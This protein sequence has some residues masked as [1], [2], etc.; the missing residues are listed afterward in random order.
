MVYVSILRTAE[1]V[2]LRPPLRYVLHKPE[3]S[4]RVQSCATGAII[5]LGPGLG[6]PEFAI[7][8]KAADER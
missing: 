4:R 5:I 6:E 2:K 3:N 7:L 1:E 8:P